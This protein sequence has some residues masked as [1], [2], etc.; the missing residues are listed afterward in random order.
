LFQWSGRKDMMNKIRV[1][2]A[3]AS[4]LGLREWKTEV[5]PTT[6][7]FMVGE[8]CNGTCGYCT[9]GGDFLSRVR[10]PPFPLDD[11]LCNIDGKAGRICIQ[12]LY[13]EGVVDDIVKAAGAMSLYGIP[14]SV[15]MNPASRKSM[16]RM[17]EAGVERVGV[18]LDCCT[19]KLFNKWKSRVP[20]WDEY[21]RWLDIAKDVFGNVT[22]HII[23]GL[24]ESDEDAVN[25]MR[26]L[27][28]KGIRIA[29][30]AYTPVQ[31]GSPPAIGR[32]HTLQIARYLIE[33]GEGRFVFRD[34]RIHKML[35][36]RDKGYENAFLT[37]GCP[38][39]NR[40]FYNERVVG[41]MYNYPRKLKGGEAEKAVE[42]VKEYV[43]IYTSIK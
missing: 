11:V 42:E 28:R 35:I 15:S 10:W 43:G 40:P 30:F 39:C 7:Y 9:Q 16:E 4:M 8:K 25:M 36:P 33:K 19:E 24:G 12:S 32:Y 22:A 21:L 31:G 20:S 5:M 6:L 37:S 34:G 38:S 41:P 17:R 14:I 3:T 29:L 27:Y 26:W 13:Y 1:S 2:A 23:I 18:G